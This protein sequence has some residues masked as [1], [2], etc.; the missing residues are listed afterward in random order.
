MSRGK[1]ATTDSHIEEIQLEATVIRCTCG[2]P[3][4][5]AGRVCPQGRIEPHGIVADYYK[6]RWKRFRVWLAR[7]FKGG[8]NAEI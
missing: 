7:K 6:S 8:R 1:V 3:A 4:S 5:H 2:A